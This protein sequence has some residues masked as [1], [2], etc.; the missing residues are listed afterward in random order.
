MNEQGYFDMESIDLRIFFN[1][2]HK[3]KWLIAGITVLAVL[4]SGVLS[5]F[6]LSPVYQSKTVIM[7]KQYQ[8]P[9]ALQRQDQQDDLQ[10]VVNSLSRIPE[11]TIKTYVDQM[12]GEALLRAVIKELKL[13]PTIYTPDSLAK[14]IDVESVQDTNLIELKVRNNDRLLAAKIANTLAE[15]FL[16][17]V[18]TSNQKQLISSSQFLSKQ[19]EQKNK[20]LAGAMTNLNKFRNQPRN[21]AYLEQELENKNSNLGAAQSQLLQAGADL[22]Q[23]LAGKITAEQSLK[24]VPQTIKTKSLNMETGNPEEKEEINPAY[25]E[26]SQLVAQKRVVLAEIEAKQSSIKASLEQLQNELKIIQ[27]ELNTKK[28]TDGSLQDKV[29]EI[30][31][32]KD[33]L[34]EKL[35]QVEI[36]KSVNLSQTTLQIV[37][38]AFPQDKPV[39]P[40]KMLNMAVAMVL[41]LIISFGL[42]LILEFTNNTINKPED[43][44]QHLGLPVLGNIP[45]ARA[46]DLN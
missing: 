44:N 40:K 28:E 1:L 41:G 12:K 45:L 30:K 18:G 15:K 37:A 9:R 8:D 4:T 19:L 10:D 26:L 24:A 32:T 35:T 11:V 46:E 36:A 27:A 25:T 42:A 43:I 33:V 17:F 16:D 14:I 21:V 7:V 31:Q 39:S 34:S 38:P 5:F 6:V 23:A 20:E 13:D 2:L 22:Q 3:W 29:D